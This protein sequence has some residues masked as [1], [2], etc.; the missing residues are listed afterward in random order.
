MYD[1][2]LRL[3]LPRCATTIAFADDLI[4]TVSGTSKMEVEVV[5]MEALE[6]IETWMTTAKLKLAHQKTE[7]MLVSNCRKTEQ[8]VM[9]IGG[10]EITSTR[11]L[12]YL[13]VMMDDR[14]SFN[15]HVDYTCEKAMKATAALGR[16]MPN[17][18][19]PR[20]SKR[21][22]LASV[23]LSIL[24]YGAPAWIQALDTWRNQRRLNKAQ[25]LISIRVAS[26]YR[27]ISLEAVCVI[28]GTMPICI[29]LTEDNKCYEKKRRDCQTTKAIRTQLRD[30]SLKQ[31]QQEWDSTDKGRW[32]HRLIPNITTWVQRKHGEVNFHLTQFLSGHGCFRKYLHRFGLTVSPFCTTC[33][34]EEETAEHVLFDCPRFEQERG[35]LTT[36]SRAEI[37]AENIISEMCRDEEVWKAADN[38]IAKIMTRLQNAWRDDQRRQPDENQMTTR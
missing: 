20:S 4:L 11:Q 38:A 18:S 6:T 24:R 34:R 12:K 31:W 8:I 30:E 35:E 32:T 5:T 9:N 15:S 22:L 2:A 3:K 25:R 7:I 27:T 14:R 21:R 26:A 28:A 33:E 19:G 1:T 17:G 23:T 36:V 16:I 10:E 13:G 29:T 37:N